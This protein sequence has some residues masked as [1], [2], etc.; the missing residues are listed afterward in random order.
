MSAVASSLSSPSPAV[1]RSPV[2]SAGVQ[3]SLRSLRQTELRLVV[4]EEV[5]FIALGAVT[6]HLIQ[7]LSTK[8]VASKSD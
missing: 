7:S 6:A 2:S 5:E 8:V 1:L 3:T 4:S